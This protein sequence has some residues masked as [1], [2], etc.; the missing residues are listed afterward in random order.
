MNGI[1]NEIK[2][3]LFNKRFLIVVF[4]IFLFTFIGVIFLKGIWQILLQ[5]A[6]ILAIII[7]D[8]FEIKNLDKDSIKEVLKENNILIYMLIN[9]ISIS[10]FIN[11]SDEKYSYLFMPIIFFISSY[12]IFNMDDKD[13]KENFDDIDDDNLS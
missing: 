9:I 12:F 3:K 13:E 8:I 1:W 7:S 4:L 11:Y 2:R 6:P 5:V 10:M